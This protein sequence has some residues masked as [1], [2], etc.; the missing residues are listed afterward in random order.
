MGAG[1]FR[2][3]P[4]MQQKIPTLG[5]TRYTIDEATLNISTKYH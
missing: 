5:I 1:E 2:R 4:M 3:A